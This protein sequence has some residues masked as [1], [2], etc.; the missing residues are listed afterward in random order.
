MLKA[1]LIHQIFRQGDTTCFIPRILQSDWLDSCY[2]PLE[3]KTSG[4]YSWNDGLC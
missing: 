3:C 1:I 2:A 4:A